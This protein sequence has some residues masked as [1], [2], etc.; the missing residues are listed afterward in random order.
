MLLLTKMGR[1]EPGTNTTG[2]FHLK[3]QGILTGISHFGQK[4][5]FP[6]NIPGHINCNKVFRNEGYW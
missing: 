4:I 5:L 6:I 3:Y 2:V 1:N